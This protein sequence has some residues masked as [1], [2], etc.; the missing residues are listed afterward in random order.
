MLGV[1]PCCAIVS[2]ADLRGLPGVAHTSCFGAGPVPI[3]QAF[4]SSMVCSPPSADVCHSAAAQL[5]KLWKRFRKTLPP[6]SRDLLAELLLDL[7]LHLLPL[8]NVSAPD[9]IGASRYDI[10]GIAQLLAV[11]SDPAATSAKPTFNEPPLNNNAASL[12]KGHFI[13]SQPRPMDPMPYMPPPPPPPPVPVLLGAVR[14]DDLETFHSWLYEPVPDFCGPWFPVEPTFVHASPYFRYGDEFVPE[15]E[16][17]SVQ[18]FGNVSVADDLCVVLRNDDLSLKPAVLPSHDD[19]S[20]YPAIHH[21]TGI[22]DYYSTDDVEDQPSTRILEPHYHWEPCWDYGDTNSFVAVPGLCALRVLS[23]RCHTALFGLV[24]DTKYHNPSFRQYFVEQT[25]LDQHRKAELFSAESLALAPKTPSLVQ[26][27]KPT[28]QCDSLQSN[29][30]PGQSMW[31]SLAT[32][33]WLQI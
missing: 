20:L 11:I 1:V 30:G 15:D 22:S 29:A 10:R 28:M 9:C 27:V 6:S 3:S 33:P 23:V 21:E 17:E 18:C 8:E 5:G 26:P 2:S 7:R 14:C 12:E 25:L 4:A 32:P 16:P 31:A 24:S 19:F 13:S